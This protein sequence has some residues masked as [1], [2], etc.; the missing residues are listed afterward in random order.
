M[1]ASNVVMGTQQWIYF[2]LLPSCELFRNT[3]TDIQVLPSSCKYP[4]FL[5]DFSQIWS[6]TTT[7]RGNPQHKILSKSAQ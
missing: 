3:A 4:I 2:A 6:A 7:F 5:S 1:K